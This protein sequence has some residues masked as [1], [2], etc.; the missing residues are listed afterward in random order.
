MADRS[1]LLG[2]GSLFAAAAMFALYGPLT[3]HVSH[4]FGNSSQIVARL[5]I[6]FLVAGGFFLVQRR[7]VVVTKRHHLRLAGLG[8]SIAGI[9]AFSTI[10]FQHTKIANTTFLLYAGGIVMALLVG[11]AVFRERINSR[12]AVALALAVTGLCIYNGISF[13]ADLATYTGLLAGCCISFT[14]LFRKLLLD[15][16]RS[17]VVWGSLGYALLVSLA[18]LAVA[19]HDA[20]RGFHA[21]A[22]VAVVLFGILIVTQSQLV[23]YGYT[24]LNLSTGAVILST[25]V[26]FGALYGWIGYG[27]TPNGTE[28]TGAVLVLLGAIVMAFR[29]P[30]AV[31]EPTVVPSAAIIDA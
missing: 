30:K 2:T 31:P 25:E 6:G 28:F 15:Q 23:T 17:L 14:G 1:H 16:S 5:S 12:S 10:S 18:V 9:Y 8:A 4:S 3:R 11:I 21:D 20:Y 7:R 19:H 24:H 26:A 27:E 22:F 13:S 29:Q